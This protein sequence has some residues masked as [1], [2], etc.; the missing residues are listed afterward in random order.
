MARIADQCQRLLSV[1]PTLESRARI[2][3][4]RGDVFPSYR[5]RVGDYRVFYEVEE[6]A[7]RVMIYGVV[8]KSQVDEWLMTFQEE[9]SDEEDDTP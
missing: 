2:K 4:L 9:Q 6:D 3:R 1:N 8:S 7:Q 5:L